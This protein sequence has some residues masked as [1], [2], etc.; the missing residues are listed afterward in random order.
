[1]MAMA[2]LV[3][4]AAQKGLAGIPKAERDA[5]VEKLRAIANDPYGHHPSAKRLQGRQASVCG[6]AAGEQFTV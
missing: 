2:L 1:M 6:K 3:R 5:L 4:P